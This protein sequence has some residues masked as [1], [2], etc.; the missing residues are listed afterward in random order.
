MENNNKLK[1]ADRLA[2]IDTKLDMV[3]KSYN[4]MMYAMLGIIAAT[5]G[6]KFIGT[7]PLTT[8]MVW[9]AWFALAFMIGTTVAN[10]KKLPWRKIIV[11]VTFSFMLLFSVVC[12]TFVYQAGLD[13]SPVWFIPVIDAFYIA[14]CGA[15]ILSTWKSNDY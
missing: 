2:R 7:P 6:V 9:L 14:V 5:V 15:L 11:R 1:T 3:L 13:V 8:I 12:R 10:R 4:K